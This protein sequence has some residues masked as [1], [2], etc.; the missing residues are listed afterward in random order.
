M[1]IGS[2]RGVSGGVE[3]VESEPAD[4]ATASALCTVAM[5]DKFSGSCSGVT[6]DALRTR[7]CSTA[8]AGCSVL[9]VSLV[10]G[11]RSTA[12]PPE[13]C[14]VRTVSMT[15]SGI[16]TIPTCL[17]ACSVRS[18]RLAIIERKA[19]ACSDG[20][21]CAGAGAGAAFTGARASSGSGFKKLWT[22]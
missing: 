15:A 3:S 17:A 10:S 11:S 5:L 19:R 1:S 8:T 2:V 13:S 22:G 6:G 14:A 4:A 20:P 12:P 16:A 18:S 21:V 9:S 7:S